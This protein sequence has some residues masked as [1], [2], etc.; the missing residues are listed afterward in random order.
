MTTNPTWHRRLSWL[1]LFAIIISGSL[2][3][4]VLLPQNTLSAQAV[5]KGHTK[6]FPALHHKVSWTSAAYYAQLHPLRV[7]LQRPGTKPNTHPTHPET[8]KP[9]PGRQP[10][11]VM[12]GQNVQP[13]YSDYFYF[14]FSAPDPADATYG[15]PTT[16][17]V[18]ADDDGAAYG[19]DVYLA[20]DSGGSFSPS[21]VTL[22]SSGCGSSTFYVPTTGTVNLYAAINYITPAFNAWGGYEEYGEYPLPSVAS[23]Q[24]TITAPSIAIPPDTSY[25]NG[26]GDEPKAGEPVNLALG[27]F[28]YQHTDFSLHARGGGSISM[29]RSYNSQDNYSGPL[30]NGWTFS[31]NQSISFPSSSTASVKYSDGHTDDYTLNNGVYTPAPGIGVLSSLQQNQDGTY[32]VTHK[33]QSQDIY[34]SSG[35]LISMI[36]RNGNALTLTYN[37]SNQLTQVV[38]A[39]GLGLS[40]SYDNNGHITSVT[41][42]QGNSETYNYNNNSNLIAATDPMGGKTAYSYDGSNRMLSYTDPDGNV[43]VTNTY[44]QSGRVVQ[45]VDATGNITT[46][47][48]NTGSTQ[49]TDPLGHV[50]TYSFDFFYRETSVTNALGNVT[51]YTYDNNAELTTVTD[52][53]G[54]TTQ[55]TYDN[56]GNMLSIVDAV[57]VANANP[58][59]HTTSY[60]YDSQNHL[61]SVTDAN[62]NTSSYT[63]NAHGNMLT[64]TDANGGVTSFTYDQ[65]GQLTGS[66]SPL[67]GRHYSTYTY[68]VYGNRITARDGLGN[69]TKTAY[70]VDGRSVSTTDPNGHTTSVSFDKDGRVVSSTDA[71]AHVVMTFTYDANG[72]QLTARNAGGDTTTYTYDALNRMVK[73]TNPD[74]TSTQNI[75]DADG[76]LLKKVDSSGHT[77]TY[78]YDAANQTLTVTDPLGQVKS[79]T[80][81][82]AGNSVTMTDANGQ[83]TAY[84][85][86]AN[87]DLVQVNYADGSSVSYNLDGVGNRLGMMDSTGTTS[88]SYDRLNRL[89]SAIDGSGRTVSYVYDAASNRTRI[90]YP[91][92]RFVNYSYDNDNRLSSATDWSGKTTTY[93]YDA[94]SNLVKMTLPNSVITTYSN[95]ANNRL[96]GVT[97][98]IP[99]GVISAFKYTLDSVGNRIKVVNNGSAVEAGTAGYTYDNMGR[100]TSA[101]YPDGSSDTFSYDASGNRTKL[102]HI[103]GGNT[104]TTNYSY[105]AADELTQLQVGSTTTTFAYD[106]NG[107][108]ISRTTGSNTTSY[109]YNAAYDLTSVTNS[110]TTVNYT[111]NGDGFRLAKS[112]TANNATTTTQYVLT[113]TKVPQVLEEINA[114]GTTDE[115]Y[116]LAL[117]ASSLFSQKAKTVY[118]SYDA[119]SSV[120]NVTSATGKV[121]TAQSYDAFGN[122]RVVNGPT[123]EFQLN[124]QQT[125]SEDGLLYMRARY[126]DPTLGRFIMRDSNTGSIGCPQTQNRYAFADNNPINMMDPTG[127]LFGL[128]DVISFAAG[129]IVGGGASI[130]SQGLSNGWGNINWGRVGADAVIGGTVLWAV[131]DPVVGAVGAA[132][133]YATGGAV[134]GFVDYCFEACG[135]P[136]FNP[137]QAIVETVWGG[138]TGYGFGKLDLG[139]K[140]M[141]SLSEQVANRASQTEDAA[142]QSLLYKTSGY[143]SGGALPSWFAGSTDQWNSL[144]ATLPESVVEGLVSGKGD[145]WQVLKQL[146]GCQ[147]S[148]G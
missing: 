68:D 140:F 63:Y 37:G 103:A 115:E 48:Y 47:T 17:C 53:S 99:S 139:G 143:L 94:A 40:F 32:T 110:S 61:L 60:T 98:T 11:H 129:A 123:S 29:A 85:Y 83:V 90:T 75:Y 69:I 45:Q 136:E 104:T 19:E 105:N 67:G 125:D 4:L 133:I 126:Y 147:G 50:T 131:D 120:R 38:D 121:L 42:P 46:F 39:S 84:G 64:N 14:T 91:D 41:D 7:A 21:V 44:D 89:I 113:P 134:Q 43:V 93:K 62:S 132:T 58:N 65:Y 56:Q 51:N 12:H 25:G 79:Y 30:G 1:L 81:D 138:V 101:T 82:G 34:N 80:Y 28:T 26:H 107:N 6:L 141:D 20:V 72:N 54:N 122:L 59:G 119:L 15:V 13:N 74:G 18:T 3:S 36:D 10:S 95:D 66:V 27:N 88:Y 5:G 118:Y 52:G 96:V 86:D 87:N 2:S 33:D 127:N 23:T 116:G 73:V 114:S 22:D 49:V 128:D 117:I 144:L 146:F 148:Q 9:N 111:Y 137:T 145:P 124:G 35:R 16:I 31:Y 97:N 8:H 78:T 92:G 109:S 70:D 71:L 108:M 55:Y 24:D 100:L 76:N 142:L 57:G 77:T 130:I 112:V 102:V 135:T 106:N